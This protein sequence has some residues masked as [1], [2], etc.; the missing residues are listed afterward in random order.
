MGVLLVSNDELLE[1][2]FKQEVLNMKYNGLIWKD[3][4]KVGAAKFALMDEVSEFLRE[5]ESDWKWW[6]KV[7]SSYHKQ[8]ALFELIDVVHFALV[9]VLHRQRMHEVL[10]HIHTEKPQ[11][12]M[13]DIMDGDDPQNEFAKAVTW[14]LNAVDFNNLDMM[15]NG[16]CNIIQTGGEMLG[17]EPGEIFQAYLLKNARNHER[18]EGGVMEGK[19]DKSQE[20]ELELSC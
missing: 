3:K 4:V 6:K 5:I 17:L 16:V 11:A 15:L 2:T 14:F 18:V 10:K 9:L 13:Y 1:M 20:K 12:Q 8:K 19:Y 7:G